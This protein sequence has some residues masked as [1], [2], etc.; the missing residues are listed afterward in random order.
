MKK[1]SF[2]N[3]IIYFINV[4]VAVLLLLSVILPFLPPKTFSLLSVVNLGVSFLI[5]INVL[6]FLYWVFQLKKQFML[7]LVILLIGYFSFGSLYNFQHQKRLKTH[8][9]L[10]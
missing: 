8:R 6:F 5:I 2:R 3:K 9:T 10:K 7:S 1:L 4:V